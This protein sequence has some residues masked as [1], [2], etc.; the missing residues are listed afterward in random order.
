[1]QTVIYK[2]IPLTVGKGWHELIEPLVDYCVEHNIK[3]IQIKEKFATLR[4]YTS[5]TNAEFSEMIYKAEKLSAVTCEEC[6]APGKQRG[7]CWMY[8]AC[9]QHVRETI[10]A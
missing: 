3:V 8:T 4:F 10:S 9:D 5:S 7:M 1:M 2:G 6:G